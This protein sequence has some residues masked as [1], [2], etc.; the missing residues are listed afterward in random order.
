MKESK[1]M[2][3]YY[4]YMR[5]SERLKVGTYEV[6]HLAALCRIAPTT[7]KFLGARA[8]ATQEPIAIKDNWYI[9]SLDE[10][11]RDDKTEYHITID[12]SQ[13]NI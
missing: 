3:D 13:K 10:V 9:Y 11:M 4:A 1:Y 12:N 7:L 2:K 6:N 8:T 5:D